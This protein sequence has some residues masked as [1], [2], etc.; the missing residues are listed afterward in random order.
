MTLQLY[1]AMQRSR[2]CDD[3]DQV[4]RVESSTPFGHLAVMVAFGPTCSWPKRTLQSITAC[5]DDTWCIEFHGAAPCGT[6]GRFAG[7][8]YIAYGMPATCPLGMPQCQWDYFMNMR[9]SFVQHFKNTR[10]SYTSIYR[11][12]KTNTIVKIN[13]VKLV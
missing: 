10:P 11:E 9:P 7:S 12:H 2:E 6:I 4:V 5:F 1:E 8:D 3:K 13:A